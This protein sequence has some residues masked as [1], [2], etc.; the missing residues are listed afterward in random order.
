MGPFGLTDE[1][2]LAEQIVREQRPRGGDLGCGRIGGRLWHREAR[3]RCIEGSS[4]RVITRALRERSVWSKCRRLGDAVQHGKW[5]RSG[6]EHVAHDGYRRR[7]RDLFA[8][9][10]R[11]DVDRGAGEFVAQAVLG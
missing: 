1:G 5:E 6:R 2:E 8:F 11:P 10:R 3:R 7:R 9:G 4:S